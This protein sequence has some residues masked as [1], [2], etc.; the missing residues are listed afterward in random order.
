MPDYIETPCD[1]PGCKNRPVLSWAACYMCG[2]V[3]CAVHDT[4]ETHGC[5]GIADWKVRRQLSDKTTRRYLESIIHRLRQ[6]QDGI[7][8]DCSGLRPGRTCTLAIPNDGDEI[9]QSKLLGAFNVNFRL[10]FDDGVE[11]MVRVR[12]DEDHPGPVQVR[13][14]DIRIEVAT[15][16]WLKANG[17]LV[18]AAWLPSHMLDGSKGASGPPLDYFYNELI[19]GSPWKV[20]KHITRT[21]DLPAEQLR[22][23]IEA[24][25]QTQIQLS[26][27]E[28]PVDKIGCLHVLPADQGVVAGPMSTR[29]CLRSPK[30]PYLLGPF[31]SLRERY[32]AHIDAALEFNILGAFSPRYR[33]ASHLWHLELRE[34][35]SNC[36]ILAETPDKLYLRHDDAKGDHMLCDDKHEV[37]AIIDWQWAYVT[38]KGEAFAPPA[39]FYMDLNYVFKGDNSLRRDEKTL[40][41]IY[42]REG[43]VDLADCVR[44]G[45]LYQRLSRIGQYDVI[46][47]KKAFRQ[48]LGPMNGGFN[49]PKDNKEWKEAMLERYKDNEGLKQVIDKFG[50]DKQ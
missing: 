33:V 25:A 30:P 5:I 6:C 43:R 23:F 45:R 39:I 15:L 42:E 35:V 31:V 44:N 22:Q 3:R 27:V 32:L 26:N 13:D 41:E 19:S 48:V 17:V 36:S 4:S 18:P 21:I 47:D 38:T 29:T 14:A 10:T 11:W 46:Y 40:I 7:I 20:E 2:E 16:Q 1:Y 49:P 50:M 28:V 12:Q 37:A 9:T 24:Y 8:A 34:L